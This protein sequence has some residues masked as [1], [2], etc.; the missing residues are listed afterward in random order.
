MQRERWGNPDGEDRAG[1]HRRDLFDEP[2]DGR[3][4]IGQA[5]LQCSAL[6]GEVQAVGMT[7]EQH[8]T[9]AAFE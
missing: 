8:V 9:E 7:L 3:E 2:A 5:G 4:C 6:F 1:P